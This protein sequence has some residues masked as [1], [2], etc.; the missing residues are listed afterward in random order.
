MTGTAG[1]SLREHAGEYLAMRRALGF[2][3]TTFGWRLMSFVTYLEQNG[4]AVITADAAVT[5]AASP[6]R[7]STAIS[8]ARPA[9]GNWSQATNSPTSSS[10]ASRQSRP[11]NPM[12][13]Q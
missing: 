13:R 11:R 6:A 3:L 4:H 10:R 2:K 12:K 9:G 1:K 7:G 5:W 8:P